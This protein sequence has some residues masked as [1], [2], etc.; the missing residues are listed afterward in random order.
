VDIAVLADIQ[1]LTTHPAAGQSPSPR[2]TPSRPPAEERLDEVIRLYGNG[3]S[4]QRL[5]ERYG[6]DDETVRQ[7]LKRLG[8]RAEAVGKI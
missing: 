7:S 8:V 4:C 6:C 5:A 3:W 2:T 1:P